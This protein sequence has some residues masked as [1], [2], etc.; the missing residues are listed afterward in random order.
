MPPDP[1]PSADTAIR[2]ILFDFG[3]V[4]CAFDTRRFLSALGPHCGLAPEVLERRIYGSDLPRAYEAGAL[5]SGE[6]LAGVSEL[7][8][9]TFPEEVFVPAFTDIFT[10]IPTTFDLL[11]RLSPRYRLGLVSN[12]NPWHV[13]HGIRTTD[14][15]PLFEAVSFS[16]EVRAM[17]PDRRIFE[18]ALAKLRLPARSC[19]FIDDVPAFAE[20]ATALG[21][22]GLTYLGPESLAAE[23]RG[24]GVAF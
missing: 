18:D 24:L 22:H 20:A 15:F 17:K 12:T 9:Y 11:R 7:C 8:G 6:F 3:N 1:V 13:E 23:L 10:P 5:S 2:A 16:H 19:V 4:I 14:V 21:M